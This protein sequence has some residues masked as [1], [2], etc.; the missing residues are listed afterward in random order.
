[1]WGIWKVDKQ[2]G[3]SANILLLL[4]DNADFLVWF[5]VCFFFILLISNNIFHD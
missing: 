2:Q 5:W 1:M 3:S 4:I